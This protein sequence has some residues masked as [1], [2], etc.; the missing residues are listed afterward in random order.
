MKTKIIT[1]LKKEILVVED[2]D[3]LDF[4][5][6]T[7]RILAF[8]MK[9]GSIKIFKGNYTLLGKV[10]EIKEEDVL[11]LVEGVGIGWFEDYQDKK[12]GMFKTALESFL[13]AIEKEIY[14]VN[15][16]SLIFVKN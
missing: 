2:S 10:D 6:I 12:N 9:D 14:W 4:Y 7:P 11:E 3:E 13:S 15:P 5:E 16:V 8:N 1:E